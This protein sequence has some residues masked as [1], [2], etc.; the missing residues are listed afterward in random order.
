[1]AG[2]IHLLPSDPLCVLFV[3]DLICPL[4]EIWVCSLRL[5]TNC[6]LS[7][8]NQNLKNVLAECRRVRTRRGHGADAD[9]QNPA[10]SAFRLG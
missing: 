9:K 7:F 1:M 6:M 10:V 3:S 4:R 2:I 8:S 5:R